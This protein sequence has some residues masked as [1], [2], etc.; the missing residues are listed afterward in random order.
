MAEHVYMCS[1]PL[2]EPLGVSV[3]AKQCSAPEHGQHDSSQQP[4]FK[5]RILTMMKCHSNIARWLLSKV[6][7]LKLSPSILTEPKLFCQ[8]KREKPLKGTPSLLD[9]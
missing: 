4:V 3:S 5:F 6:I 2:S 7:M 8:E 9:H 1:V